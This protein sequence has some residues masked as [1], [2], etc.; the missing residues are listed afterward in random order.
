[1]SL[2]KLMVFGK[3][4]IIKMVI[5]VIITLIMMTNND[6]SLDCDKGIPIS[7][8]ISFGE[9]AKDLYQLMRVVSH[10]PCKTL[11]YRR[12]HL[13]D[14]KFELHRALNEEREANAQKVSF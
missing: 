5:L 7:K 1:M 13:L 2:K 3:F 12:L 14:S 9:Y 11:C 10:G 6:F 8:I 4:L